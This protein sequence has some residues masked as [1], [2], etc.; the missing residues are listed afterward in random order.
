MEEK[1]NKADINNIKEEIPSEVINELD[2]EIFFSAAMARK[3][4]LSVH[5]KRLEVSML[6]IYQK[7][8]DA[9][10]EGKYSIQLNLSKDERNFLSNKNFRTSATSSFTKNG[11]QFYTCDIYWN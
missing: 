3:K 5:K 7:I 10:A 9:I 4:T 6:P 8:N 1:I 11:E 2:K